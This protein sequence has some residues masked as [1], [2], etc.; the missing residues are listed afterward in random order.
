[1]REQSLKKESAICWTAEMK[2][3]L[4]NGKHLFDTRGK[5]IGGGRKKETNWTNQRREREIQLKYW[6][7]K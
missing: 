1:M 7:D 4:L 5:M 2:K 6:S 3:H